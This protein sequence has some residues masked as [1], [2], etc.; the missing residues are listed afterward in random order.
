MTF[1]KDCIVADNLLLSHR[2]PE[3]PALVVHRIPNED[4][5]VVVRL[6]AR[7]L[8]L[9]YMYIGQGAKNAKMRYIW[10]LS[11]PNFEGCLVF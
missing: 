3:N 9:L 1:I 6:E 8:V 10:L 11:K 4:A 7:P 2:I 5:L